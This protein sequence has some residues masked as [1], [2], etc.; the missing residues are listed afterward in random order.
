MISQKSTEKL[1]NLVALKKANWKVNQNKSTSWRQM[2]SNN[3]LQFFNRN[4]ADS[5]LFSQELYNSTL[6]INQIN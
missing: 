2:W 6:K 1:K 4:R 5:N 3:K